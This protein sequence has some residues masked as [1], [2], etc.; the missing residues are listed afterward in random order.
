MMGSQGVLVTIFIIYSSMTILFISATNS[1]NSTILSNDTFCPAWFETYPLKLDGLCFPLYYMSCNGNHIS[2]IYGTCATYDEEADALSTVHCPF[3]RARGYNITAPGVV[4]I[5]NDVFELNYYMCS[6]LKRKGNL[7]SECVDGYAPSFNSFKDEC[8]NC[9]GAWYGIPLYLVLELVPITIF[10]LIIL[11]F[12]VNLTLAPMTCFIMYSQLVLFI[13]SIKF[14]DPSIKQLMFDGNNFPTKF[15]MAVFTGYGVWNL[16]FLRYVVPPFCVS[17]KLKSIHITF[18]GYISAFYPLCLIMF[19]WICIELHD[20]NFRP[21]IL[22]CRWLRVCRVRLRRGYNNKGDIISV[23]ASFFLLSYTKVL[24]RGVVL[25]MCK[26]VSIFKYHSHDHYTKHNSYISYADLRVSCGS[27]EYFA[28]AIPAVTIAFLFNFLPALLILIYP[29]LRFRR[30]LSKCRLDS[31]ALKFFIERLQGCYKDNRFGDGG[32]DMRCFSALY[33]FL[34]MAVLAGILVVKPFTGQQLI[35]F[36]A[37]TVLLLSALLIAFCKPYKKTIMN[38]LDTLLLAHFGLLCYLMSVS[39]FFTK[40]YIVPVIK[41]SFLFPLAILILWLFLQFF[42]LALA[43]FIKP[44][45]NHMRKEKYCKSGTEIV[46]SNMTGEL[47]QPLINPTTTT[48]DISS[49]GSNIKL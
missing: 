14:E 12:Q 45:C 48:I 31:Y 36:P 41:V 1:D 4:S 20:H 49:Y 34:R 29:V 46:K 43:I 9:E 40:E 26:N 24:Y 35:W 10:Y 23:F 39:C 18:L 17:N 28:F 8:S 27:S 7:C 21:L 25:A 5:P 44:I 2:M 3:F 15:M 22:L 38:T 11:L 42:L 37:G 6:P 13:F 32:K 33:F 47:N 16:D 19:T 30:L